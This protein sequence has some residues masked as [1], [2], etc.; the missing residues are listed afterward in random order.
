MEQVVCN[1]IKVNE[2]TT[3]YFQG[4]D[5]VAH[6]SV[7]LTEDPL[8]ILDLKNYVEDSIESRRVKSESYFN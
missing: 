6:Y 3:G 1:F 4:L 5:L 2:S 8:V 7:I